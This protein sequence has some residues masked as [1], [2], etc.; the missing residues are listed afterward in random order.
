[1]PSDSDDKRLPYERHPEVERAQAVLSAATEARQAVNDELLAARA[2]SRIA[3]REALAAL[4][5]LE[6][7]FTDAAA[8]EAG[9]RQAV[10]AAL[11]RAIAELYPDL[12][13]A[14]EK[15]RTAE[16]ERLALVAEIAEATACAD[17][18]AHIAELA[19]AR[20]AKQIEVNRARR[21]VRRLIQTHGLG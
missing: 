6:T 21:D 19:A 14:Q 18:P 16:A 9:A 17:A 20:D 8:A 13:A 3:T 15:E 11:E 1:M 2:C 4:E 12:V 5:Q 7:R 10:H